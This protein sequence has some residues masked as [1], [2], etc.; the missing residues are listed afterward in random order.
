[1]P[2]EVT[3][4]SSSTISIAGDGDGDFL[5]VAFVSWAFVCFATGVIAAFATMLFT[6]LLELSGKKACGFGLVPKKT[7]KTIIKKAQVV[8]KAVMT[9]VYWYLKRAE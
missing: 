2:E 7:N 3:T 8:P 6:C 1:M 5:G 9:I 4:G